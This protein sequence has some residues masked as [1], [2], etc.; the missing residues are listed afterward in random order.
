MSINDETWDRPICEFCQKEIPYGM[1]F[2]HIYGNCLK[3]FA[4]KNKTKTPSQELKLLTKRFFEIL[5]VKEESD[6]GREFSPVFISCCRVLL[7]EELKKILARM[8]E[9]AND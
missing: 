9:L 5:D 2:E 1:A 3:D 6:S 7:G 8:K 4:P